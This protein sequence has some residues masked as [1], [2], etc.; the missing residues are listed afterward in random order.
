MSAVLYIDLQIT[1]EDLAIDSGGEPLLVNNRNSIEQDI[2]NMIKESGLMLSLIGERN[3]MLQ[4]LIFQQLTLLLESDVRLVPGSVVIT[5]LSL[6]VYAIAA[7]T[8][9]FGPVDL[10]VNL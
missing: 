7:N 4:A 1:D 10:T 9:D 5:T 2:K 6:G 3:K 8:L